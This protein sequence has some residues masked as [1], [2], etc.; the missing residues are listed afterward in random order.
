M[1]PTDTVYGL[2]CRPDNEDAVRALSALKRRSSEQPI[3]LVAANGVALTELVP[4]L[5]RHMLV[6]GAFTLVVRNPVRRLP[7]SPEPGRTRSASA[8]PT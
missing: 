5:P 7:G 4:E 1:I 3:A 2:A 6:R 8:S